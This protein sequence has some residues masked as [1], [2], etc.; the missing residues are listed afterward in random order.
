MVW[1]TDLT[2][3]S[4][5]RFR[6]LRNQLLSS[7]LLVMT[8]ILGVF[9][10]AVYGLVAHE[11]NQQF[12][13]HL[14][15]V[16]NSAASLL[17]IIKSEYEE[18]REDLEEEAERL[19][20][21][22][23]LQPLTLTELINRYQG[24]SA[25]ALPN[26]SLMTR[27]QGIEWYDATGR[28]LVQ[29]GGIFLSSP[30]PRQIF[31]EGQFTQQGTVRGFIHPVYQRTQPTPTHL[32]GYVRVT[33]STVILEA[34]LRRLRWGL[35]LGGL[36]VSGL[37]AVGGVWLTHTALKPIVQSFWQLQ[38]F[39]ADASHE[40]RSPLTA[41]RAS[42]A[43]LQNHPE[44]IHLADVDK[45]SA[46][47]EASTQMSQLVDDLLLL[48]RMD[49]QAP[50]RR[51]WHPIPLDE[52]LEDLLNLYQNQAEQAQIHLGWQLAPHLEVSGDV[53]H[54]QRLFTNLLANA[55]H[56]T[57]SGGT[58][59]VSLQGLATSALITVADTGMGITPEQLPHVFER[60]WRADQARTQDSAGS[61]L[62]LAI[63]KSIA[64]RHGGDITVQSQVGIGSQFQVILPLVS[65]NSSR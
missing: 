52:L 58:V 62:G 33:E 41:I 60:F 28:L 61:G 48:A 37:A 50:D 44:R 11:R 35:W 22:S 56:Y 9:S 45:L 6:R 64:Q 3:I 65:T 10:T 2:P 8:A 12:N 20:S 40:L 36:V 15:Q 7:Y 54:L 17:E 55:L 51:G 16:A 29:D 1:D 5:Q 59:T 31:I 53:S 63:A 23:S 25:L 34:E 27:E 24:E 26:N 13:Q 38:Q 42:I 4:N 39:T 43:V 18:V 19:L 21:L 14:H 57:H 32:L 49:R 30:L 47:A 46:I